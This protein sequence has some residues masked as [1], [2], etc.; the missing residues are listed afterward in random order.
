MA[1]AVPETWESQVAL[2]GNKPAVWKGLMERK[3]LPY[4]AAVRNLRC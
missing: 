1:L 4:L 2:H 3:K